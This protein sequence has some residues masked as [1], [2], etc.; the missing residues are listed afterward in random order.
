MPSEPQPVLIPDHVLQ[1]EQSMVMVVRWTPST[2]FH[3]N[4]CHGPDG[5][6]HG[7]SAAHN[8]RVADC[9][10]HYPSH[11]RR[12][13]AMSPHIFIA[14]TLY[15]GGRG[16]GHYP[17]YHTIHHSNNSIFHIQSNAQRAAGIAAQYRAHGLLAP[18]IINIHHH[19]HGPHGMAVVCISAQ[20]HT[21]QNVVVVVEGRDIPSYSISFHLNIQYLHL[22]TSFIEPGCG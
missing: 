18:V 6:G 4:T 16:N 21:V 9:T 17:R 19:I 20:P 14:A 12:R 8:Q 3:F 13:G 22:Q 11:Y 15:G 5:H 7:H 2:L 10:E 1:H